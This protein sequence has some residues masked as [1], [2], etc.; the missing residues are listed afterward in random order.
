MRVDSDRQSVRIRRLPV[1]LRVS[2]RRIV[3]LVFA[4]GLVVAACSSGSG[5]ESVSDRTLDDLL[6]D[7]EGDYVPLDVALGAYAAAI[8]PLPGV[9]TPAQGEVVLQSGTGPSRWV[10]AH[11]DEL[12]PEQRSAIEGYEGSTGEGVAVGRGPILATAAMAVVA[13]DDGVDELAMLDV[14]HDIENRIAAKV[15]RPLGIPVELLIAPDLVYKTAA[16]TALPIGPAG[17]FTGTPTKCRVTVTKLGVPWAQQID[18]NGVASVRLE[19][20]IAHEVW[21][22]FSFTVGDPSRLGYRP[23]WVEEGMAE[24]A[25]QEISGGYQSVWWGEWLGLDRDLYK[26]TYDAN[27]FWAHVAE[28]SAGLWTSGLDITAASD[29]GNEAAYQATLAISDPSMLT[30]WGPGYFRDP[31]NAP[32]WDQSGAGIPGI[33]IKPPTVVVGTLADGGSEVLSA[34]TRSYGIS[35]VELTAEVV[36]VSPTTFGMM[37]LPDGV[38]LSY[39]GSPTEILCTNPDGCTCPDGTPG[40]SA[41]FR[42]TIPGTARVG[43]TG[44]A[45]GAEMSL[46]GRSLADF[47]KEYEPTSTLDACLIG[48]W[49]S[50]GFTA[51]E[52]LV[53]PGT[54][55]GISLVIRGSG[56]GYFDFTGHVPVILQYASPGA[57]V[58]RVVQDGS[59]WVSLVPAG[60]GRAE[61]V[62]GSTVGYSAKGQVDMGD[63]WIDAG[64]GIQTSGSSIGTG[65]Q[66]ICEDGGGLRLGMPNESTGYFFDKISDS[67]DIPPEPPGATPIGGTGGSDGGG[68][69][70]GSGTGPPPPDWGL[71]YDACTILTAEEVSVLAPG[72]ETP[73]AEDDNSTQFL[74]QCGFLPALSIQITPPSG[75]E[76]V[77]ATVDFFGAE[78]VGLPGVVDWGHAVVDDTVIMVSGGNDKG[79]VALVVWIDIKPGTAQYDTLV[80][81][82][83]LAL[84]RL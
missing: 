16:A 43:L 29:T 61:V 70:T 8:G 23:A 40:T 14:I 7:V 39:P 72:V 27:G 47:C 75:P 62:G 2:M 58:V 36:I 54:G 57:P 69:A 48:E 31:G 64:P 82:L 45:S 15:G 55:A 21:H 56:D 25:G 51:A 49:K 19:T 4:V 37:Q 35:E 71:T 46:T 59:G 32:E 65:S 26:R 80:S 52:F 53:E 41:I 68:G 79:T 50:T 6:G 22:C 77:N 44:H 18:A 13:A 20:L 3:V 24:W 76:S 17:P 28:N 83:N 11:W 12:T 73:A 78:S 30:T 42:Q 84:S 9:E 38:N 81:L 10:R 60:A 1:V 67:G 5:S 66:I 63:G 74:H 34:K 33:E